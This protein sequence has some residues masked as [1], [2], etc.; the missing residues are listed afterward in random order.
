MSNI[1][2]RNPASILEGRSTSLFRIFVG[3]LSV[4]V[5]V[6]VIL[7]NS[8]ST[9]LVIGLITLGVLFFCPVWIKRGKTDP[10]Y[11]TWICVVLF[12]LLAREFELIDVNATVITVGSAILGIWVRKSVGLHFSLRLLALSLSIVCAAACVSGLFAPDEALTSVSYES[13]SLLGPFTH[14][15]LMGFV[16]ALGLVLSLTLYFEYQRRRA[17]LWL[18][19]PPLIAL[20]WSESRTA[21]LAGF[22]AIG[23]YAVV[24]ML[25]S[26]RLGRLAAGFMFLLGTT[27]VTVG[28]F[29]ESFLDSFLGVLGRDTT[30]TG[31]TEIWSAVLDNFADTQPFGVGWGLAWTE[32]NAF[33]EA[34]WAQT[35]FNNGHSHQAWLDLLVRV[36]ILGALPLCVFVIRLTMRLVKLSLTTAGAE[37]RIGLSLI[38]VIAVRSLTESLFHLPYVALILGLLA[39]TAYSSRPSFARSAHAS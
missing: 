35:G 37:S 23:I 3:A 25:N 4:G 9:G 32:G 31:R 11:T 5:F 15:N 2:A 22:A 29:V 18:A 28:L 7:A 38:A 10:W 1:S 30:L 13:G 19:V 36:G 39:V 20:V 24:H 17:H 14:R 16:A 27:V 6:L 34:V 21:W 12:G 8:R 26:G 33:T